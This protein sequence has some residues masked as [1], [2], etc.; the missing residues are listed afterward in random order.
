MTHGDAGAPV[1]L[2]RDCEADRVILDV[3]PLPLVFVR[4][5]HVAHG[6]A[7]SCAS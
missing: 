3:L 1:P 7:G 4:V 5:L 2:R 6:D